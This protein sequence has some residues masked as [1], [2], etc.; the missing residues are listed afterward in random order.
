MDLPVNWAASDAMIDAQMEVDQTNLLTKCQYHRC[1][2]F[3]LRKQK[4]FAKDESPESRI[5]RQCRCGAGI[6]KTAEQGNTPG[7]EKRNKPCISIA[8]AGYNKLELN[9]NDRRVV[10]TSLTNLRAGEPMWTAKSSY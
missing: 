6:E 4:K 8:P 3:C 7:F 2:G 9:Q 1:N 5:R 10:Q